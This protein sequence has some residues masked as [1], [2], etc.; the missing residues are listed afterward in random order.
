MSAHHEGAEERDEQIDQGLKARDAR[1][2][3]DGREEIKVQNLY[4]HSA[5]ED[6]LKQWKAPDRERVSVWAGD[7]F[8]FFLWKM[9]RTIPTLSDHYENLRKI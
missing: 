6:T 2:Q 4:V 5:R 9:E 7:L 1:A 3:N 8:S